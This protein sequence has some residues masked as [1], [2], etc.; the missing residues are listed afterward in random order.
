ME[1]GQRKIEKGRQQ[2][3]RCMKEHIL[4]MGLFVRIAMSFSSNIS[5]NT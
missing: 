3:F 1:R 2:N 4:R 5:A